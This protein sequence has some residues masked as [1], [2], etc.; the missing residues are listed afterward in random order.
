MGI[1]GYDGLVE[2]S[3]NKIPH[4]FERDLSIRVTPRMGMEVTLAMRAIREGGEKVVW[5]C[6]SIYRDFFKLKVVG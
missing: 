1:A 3:R 2:N 5:Q 6:R 4:V